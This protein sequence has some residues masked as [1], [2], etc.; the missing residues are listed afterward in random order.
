MF[1]VIVLAYKTLQRYEKT[2]K[3]KDLN[4][5]CLCLFKLILKLLP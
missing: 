5:N 1:D 4:V 3:Q 2:M